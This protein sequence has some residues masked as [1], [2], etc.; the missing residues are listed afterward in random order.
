[1]YPIYNLNKP[2]DIISRYMHAVDESHINFGSFSL[3]TRTILNFLFFSNGYKL[4][5]QV[6]ISVT[7]IVTDGL[8]NF[9]ILVTSAAINFY[10][11]RQQQQQTSGLAS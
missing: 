9:L 8:I 1:M 11:I 4:T 10:H 2:S 7:L 5:W 6:F 3:V